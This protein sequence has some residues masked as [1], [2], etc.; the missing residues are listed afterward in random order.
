MVAYQQSGSIWP[1]D[2]GAAYHVGAGVTLWQRLLLRGGYFNAPEHFV[3]LYGNHF[4]GTLSVRN[5]QS[6]DGIGTHTPMWNTVM[7]LPADTCWVPRASFSRA[8]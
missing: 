1:F 4:F 6:Y 2:G 5:G 3:S 8:V 7:C